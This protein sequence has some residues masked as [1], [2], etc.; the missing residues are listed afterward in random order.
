M[1]SAIPRRFLSLSVFT[2]CTIAIMSACSD[3]AAPPMASSDPSTLRA[4]AAA[5]PV[6]NA[7]V[8]VLPGLDGAHPRGIDEF[9]EVVGSTAANV[10]FYWSPSNGLVLLA[11]PGFATGQ[12]KTINDH[13]AMSGTLGGSTAIV[14]M[15]LHTGE[16]RVFPSPA[17]QSCSASVLTWGGELVGTCVATN[18]TVYGTIFSW[19]GAPTQTAG[20]EYN[21]LSGDGYLVGAQDDNGVLTAPI[22]VLPSG[23]LVVLHGV[24][25]A[26]H[27][28]SAVNAVAEGGYLAG[29]STEAG[30]TQAVVWGLFTSGH[31]TWPE[32]YLDACGEANGITSDGYVV[33]TSFSGWAFLWYE[34]PGPGLQRL[35]GLGQAGETSTAVAISLHHALGT[36]TSN[37]VTHTVIWNLPN[38][39]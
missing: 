36:I 22:V 29:Y 2:T 26:I 35:P 34:E 21:D 11:H 6:V 10:P 15:P 5:L 13:G 28:W 19:H 12:A 24:D 18:G 7:V 17:S 8:R 20:Y 14:W 4:S 38:R 23:Q 30:C 16:L 25:G 37:G 9:D 3:S 27:K 39:T 31:A 32:R 33:G 1:A